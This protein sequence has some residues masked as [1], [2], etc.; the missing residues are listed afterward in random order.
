MKRAG[1]TILIGP[2]L[3]LP[4]FKNLKYAF[5]SSRGLE[6]LAHYVS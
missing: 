6:H 1:I 4:E 3:G 5:Y 2:D